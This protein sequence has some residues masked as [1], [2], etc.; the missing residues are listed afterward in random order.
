M[1]CKICGDAAVYNYDLKQIICS[2]CAD[3]VAPKISR[4][5]FDSRYWG[6]GDSAVPNATKREFYD[7]YLA[8]KLNFDEYLKQ[9][10]VIG[11]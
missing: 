6:D 8:S 10:S 11:Y 4:D 7:D 1:T 9:T 2:A 5:E 3:G